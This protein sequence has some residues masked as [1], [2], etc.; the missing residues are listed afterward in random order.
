MPLGT[1]WRVN[2]S[3]FSL[4]GVLVGG[5]MHHVA[6]E[7]SVSN[8]LSTRWGVCH[9]VRRVPEDV[10]VA[11]LFH[12]ARKRAAGEG[13]AKAQQQDPVQ[14]RLYSAALQWS[15]Q[16]IAIF[17]KRR[18]SQTPHAIAPGLSAGESLEGH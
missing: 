14:R 7:L 15:W 18:I 4:L 12:V 17:E 1:S 13:R 9:Y 11:F 8:H 6:D 5:R 2:L 10:R 3:S 16:V